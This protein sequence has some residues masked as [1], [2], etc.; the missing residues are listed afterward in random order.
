MEKT[1]LGPSGMQV[2]RLCLGTWNMCGSEGWGPDDDKASIDLIRRA[3]EDGCNFLD[4][5]RGYGNG[6]SE[7]VL[8]EA[9]RDCR[10]DVIL[11][12]KMVHCPPE[13]VAGNIDKSLECMQTDYI[14]LYI[15]HWPSPSLSLEE[16]FQAMVEE[17]DKGRIKAI[18][19]SNFS[20]AQMEIAIK[21]DVCSL[22]PPL[23]ILWRI[24]DDTMDFCRE[25]SVAVTPYSP[26][27]QGLLTGRYTRGESAITGV[28]KNNLLFAGEVYEKSLEVARQVDA[29]ADRLGCLSSQVALAW[30]LRTPGITSVIVGASSVEQ[31]EQDVGALD[32][33]LSDEDY[34][35]LDRHGKAVWDMLGPDETMWGWK[36][37]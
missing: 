1:A 13:K 29:I 5:A 34:A 37:K 19:V 10:K 15:C 26:L 28:R 30:L 3:V 23:S 7:Q 21:Y 24:T 17:R 16:F 2:S 4:S 35:V 8:G 27:A 14:D 22:Q 31:W 18:G 20:A 25:S 9:V 32:I 11:A 33:E 36:P 6:H 12:T